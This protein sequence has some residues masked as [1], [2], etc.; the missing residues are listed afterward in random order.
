MQ[1]VT[2]TAS[3]QAELHDLADKGEAVAPSSP[4]S[5]STPD[6]ADYG[7]DLHIN[8]DDLL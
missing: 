7:K 3:K 2:N 1:W 6:S 8:L 5:P 4:L